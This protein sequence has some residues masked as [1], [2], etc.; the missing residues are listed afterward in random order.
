[1]TAI[2]D[3]IARL[4]VH[5]LACTD[6]K[7]KAAPNHPVEDA[8]MLPL[9]IA[10]ISAGTA[11]ADNATTVRMLLDLQVDGHFDRSIIRQ[12]YMQIDKF[13]PDY[14]K[15]LAGDPTLN[16]KV[17]T[18]NFPLEFTVG[19]AEFNELITQMVSFRIPV[20]VLTTPTT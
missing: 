8:G 19:P 16:G 20:K 7:I 10:Y 15:L 12:T 4:Q 18:I 5:A 14:I 6:P 1:M 9:A 3:A 11:Q 2:D 17:S 13:I